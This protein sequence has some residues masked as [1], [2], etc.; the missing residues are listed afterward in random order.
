MR[1]CKIGHNINRYTRFWKLI[2]SLFSPSILIIIRLSESLRSRF[3]APQNHVRVHQSIVC[4]FVFIRVWSASWHEPLPWPEALNSCVLILLLWSI[5][6]KRALTRSVFRGEFFFSFAIKCFASHSPRRIC[7]LGST[8]QCSLRCSHLNS[9][10]HLYN[11]KSMNYVVKYRTVFMLFYSSLS[12]IWLHDQPLYN[13][14]TTVMFILSLRE[15]NWSLHR[16]SSGSGKQ[17]LTVLATTQ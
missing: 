13:E 7:C 15:S 12:H 6:V 17:N 16:S 2:A 8:L 1:S 9:T 3:W 10:Y 11:L 4:G 14:T 5:S